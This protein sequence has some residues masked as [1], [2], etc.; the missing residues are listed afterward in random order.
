MRVKSM[1]KTTF[2]QTCGSEIWLCLF[3]FRPILLKQLNSWTTIDT[4]SWLGDLWVGHHTAVPEVPDSIT[5][6]DK[7]FDF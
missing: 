4:F 3:M 2:L 1:Q 5:G 6:F 7:D